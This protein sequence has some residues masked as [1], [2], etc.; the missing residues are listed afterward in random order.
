M[1][2]TVLTLFLA[3][4]STVFG[5]NAILESGTWCDANLALTASTEGDA[6][7]IQWFK[8]G[9]ALPGET[10]AE[11][12]C[13]AYG[14]GLYEVTFVQDG[15][16]QKMEHDLSE[17]EGPEANFK[18][19]NYLA[20]A[21]TFFEDASVSD[22]LIT[23]WHWDFGN[24]ETSEEKAPRVMFSEQKVYTITL[25]VTTESGC[26]NTIIRTHKWSYE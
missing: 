7:F 24:G 13:V 12:N 26:Q 9:E 18:A 4:F 2:F 25:T 15:L 21:V 10:G 22:E 1:K 17:T 3:F 16:T 11:I 23:A 19:I 6:S 20:A 14:K 5:Q 8:D